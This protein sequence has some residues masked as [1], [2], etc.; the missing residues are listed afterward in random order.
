MTET[1]NFTEGSDS[2]WRIK[3]VPAKQT[4][5]LSRKVRECNP[6]NK[7]QTLIAY[8][9]SYTPTSKPKL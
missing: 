8:F 9:W 7:R 2:T 5:E 6:A 3:E 4:E 1:L